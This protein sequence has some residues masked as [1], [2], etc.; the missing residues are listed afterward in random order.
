MSLSLNRARSSVAIAAENSNRR[1]LLNDRREKSKFATK[2]FSS[3]LIE[4]LVF[5]FSSANSTFVTMIWNITFTISNWARI[6]SE[7]N[8]VFDTLKFENTY[9]VNNSMFCVWIRNFRKSRNDVVL[10]HIEKKRNWLCFFSWSRIDRKT[11]LLCFQ[12][13]SRCQ[14]NRF[15]ITKMRIWMINVCNCW[16]C[17]KFANIRFENCKNIERVSYILTNCERSK[18]KKRDLS[19]N[20]CQNLLSDLRSFYLSV[21]YWRKSRFHRNSLIR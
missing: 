14:N 16:K 19:Y 5:F 15:T 21:R 18:K 12:R 20:D 11:T 4:T 7:K 6:E 8:L 9:W 13:F 10:E 1:R 17:V 3:L 2:W